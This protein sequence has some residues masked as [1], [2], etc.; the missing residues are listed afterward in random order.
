MPLEISS[1]RFFISKR[2]GGPKT[3]AKDPLKLF[4]IKKQI[5]NAPRVRFWIFR[6]FSVTLCSDKVMFSLD[7]LQIR[8]RP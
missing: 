7:Q 8:D 4:E 3:S 5:L 6:Y 2:G 1:T